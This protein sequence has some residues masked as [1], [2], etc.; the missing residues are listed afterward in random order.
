MDEPFGALDTPTRLALQRE[1]AG[2]QRALGSTVV[3]VTHDLDEALRL[4]QRLVLLDEGRIVQNGTPAELL[5]RPAS[6]RVRDHLGRSAL[7]ERRLALRRVADILRNGDAADGVP[8]LPEQTLQQ[9]L[10][11]FLVRRVDR[12]PVADAQGRPIGAIR[13]IDLLSDP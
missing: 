8:L 2:I 6:E 1:L 9:A 13:F 7:G 3:L 10:A 12:L 5:T 4:G 11:E